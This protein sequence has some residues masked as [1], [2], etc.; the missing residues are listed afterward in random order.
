MSGILLPGQDKKPASSGGLE[1]AGGFGKKRDERKEKQSEQASAPQVAEAPTPAASDTPS[2]EKP[3]AAPPG[4]GRRS[5][6]DFLFPPTPAQVQ[7]PNCST[8]YIVPIFSIIDLGANPELKSPLLSG[9]INAAI[10]PNCGAGGMLT[11]PLMVH[12]PDHQFLG[13]FIPAEAR[14]NEVQRQKAIGDLSQALMR[15]IPTEARKGYMLQPKQY[16]DWQR[17][18]EKL[19]EFEGVTPE[20]LR[21]QRSQSELLQ[22]LLSLANDPKA[23]EIALQ[24][25][26]DLVDRTF[27]SMLDRMLLM[28][29]AQNQGEPFVQLRSNLL[30]LTEVGRQVKAQG[31]RIR[32]IL[33]QIQPNTTRQEILETL[34][35]A[36][37][38]DDGREIV[39]GLVGALGPLLD[40][41]FLLLLTDHIEKTSDA[42]QR[43]R[44]DEMRQMVLGMQEQQRQNQQMMAQ[45]MQQVLQE[46]LQAEDVDAKLAELAEYIDESFLAIL[47]SNIQT[48]QKRGSKAAAQR[49]QDIYDRAIAMI[50]AQMPPEVRLVNQL[51]NANGRSEVNQLLDEHRHMLNADFLETLKRFENE[52]RNNRR[53]E[54]ADRIK[55]LRGQIA[56]KI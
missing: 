40:Y 36:G 9:Q 28:A 51:L 21:R 3:S 5:A 8:P 34:E 52:M 18:S 33:S 49:L 10:C 39:A 4:A 56:L 13:A 23:L 31:E 6:S 1:V 55:S 30:E 50:E 25:N 32:A 37:K 11:A 41:E 20:M 14:I 19:W 7:C 17:F 47:A 54:V 22:S 44:L 45:Q 35:A 16:I 46:V 43:Q 29:G 2:A 42:G 26:G 24:R 48:A 53:S 12:I 15:K 38:A 27:F